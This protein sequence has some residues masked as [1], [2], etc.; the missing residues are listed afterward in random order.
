MSAIPNRQQLQ[1]EAQE[2][3]S[4]FLRDFKPRL[5][6][7]YYERIYNP[8][9][10]FEQIGI[11]KICELI[12]QGNCLHNLAETMDI[13]TNSLRKWIRSKKEYVVLLQEAYVYAGE[14]FAYKAEQALK[15]SIGRSKEDISVA[16]KLAEHYRWMASRLNKEMFGEVKEDKN[17]GRAPAVINLNLVG[18]VMPEALKTVQGRVIPDFMRLSSEDEG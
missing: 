11:N 17:S 18:G 15:A 6:S 9:A 7:T 14:M 16:G 4:F 8:V 2:Q 13:S 5:Y 12:E 10:F 3:A 1:Q